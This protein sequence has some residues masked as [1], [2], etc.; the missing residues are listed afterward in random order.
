[1]AIKGYTFYI[2]GVKANQ[3]PQGSPTFTFTGLDSNS[4]HDITVEA[5]D[6]AG[7]VSDPG[8]LEAS[9]L[10]Y[11]YVDEPMSPS[12]AGLIDAIMTDGIA[13]GT[14]GGGGQIGIVGPNGY[15]YQAYGSAYGR[16]LT[17]DDRMR[18]GSNTK[19]ATATLIL[20]QI[21]AGHLSF[22]DKLADFISGIANG[23]RI[24]IKHLL[25]MRSGIKDF[26]QDDYAN[27]QAAFLQPTIG[28]D[29][30]P[31][32][33]AYDAMDEPGFSG[34]CHY[35]NSNYF[36]L[37][38]I[39]ELLDVTYGTSRAWPQILYED[40]CVPFG[41]SESGIPSGLYM[42]PPYSRGFMYNQAYPTI[43]ALGILAFLAPLFVPGVELTEY[44]ERTSQ[45]LN[46]CLGTGDMAGTIHD[47]VKFGE[48]LRDGTTLSPEI[49][50]LRLELFETYLT[51]TPG[52]LPGDGDGW[53]GCG[54]GLMQFGQWFGWVGAIPAYNTTVWF[55]PYNSAV[56]AITTNDF[57][58]SSVS[59]FYAVR[60]AL[61]PDT[62]HLTPQIRR[63]DA[64]VASAEAFGTPKAIVYHAPGD[65]DAKTDV[66]LKVPFYI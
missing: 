39:L 14:H 26:L 47:M 1:M 18:W 59:M 34:P 15:Y 52:L 9:T 10:T 41:M 17:V 13:K 51:Y 22:D 45:A 3:I 20:A 27:Q 61:W 42:D 32:I 63:A 36:L 44:V 48:G 5:V 16:P 66:P 40:F 58:C 55:N 50:Q 62:V 56:I 28:F 38:K 24:T 6:Y 35:S 4:D 29:P 23:D 65:G 8:E 57:M 64:S 33:R 7:N 53:S 25:M 30:L 49:H 60:N 12:D 19:M 21:D 11:T 31:K 37:A 2:D 54:L 43:K 46:Y